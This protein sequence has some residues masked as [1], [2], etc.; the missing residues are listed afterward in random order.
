MSTDKGHAMQQSNALLFEL[1]PGSCCVFQPCIL[2]HPCG[3]LIQV[4]CHLT[5]GLICQGMPSSTESESFVRYSVQIHGSHA[6]SA[7]KLLK[8]R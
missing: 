8:A 2:D 4:L 5:G 6:Q 3:A 7:S 1:C